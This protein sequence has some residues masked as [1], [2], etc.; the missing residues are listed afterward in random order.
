MVSIKI[1]EELWNWYASVARKVGKSG[2]DI[3]IS[4]LEAGQA[5]MLLFSVYRDNKKEG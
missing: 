5:I 3:I 1:D 4:V 2:E